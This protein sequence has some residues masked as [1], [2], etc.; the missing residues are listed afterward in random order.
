MLLPVNNNNTG[1]FTF[2]LCKCGSSQSQNNPVWS[3]YSILIVV[4]CT[5]NIYRDILAVCIDQDITSRLNRDTNKMI[6]LL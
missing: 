3:K 1:S 6:V 5:F 2:T 4:R